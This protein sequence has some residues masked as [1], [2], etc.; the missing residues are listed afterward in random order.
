MCIKKGQKYETYI[1]KKAWNGQD[2]TVYHEPGLPGAL[3]C[4]ESEDGTPLYIDS[5]F[6][7]HGEAVGCKWFEFK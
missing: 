3:I 6:N 5:V 1:D 2:V 4:A 7:A